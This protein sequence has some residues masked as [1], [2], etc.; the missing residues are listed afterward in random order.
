[1]SYLQRLKAGNAPTTATHIT[2]K[3]PSVGSVGS[4]SARL[5]PATPAEAAELRAYLVRHCG[6]SHPD[7][8]EALAFAFAHPA[9]HLD[10]FRTDAEAG[11]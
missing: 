8:P 10:S 4:L 5:S 2:D 3:S 11:L 7:F 1:M 9:M 6:E